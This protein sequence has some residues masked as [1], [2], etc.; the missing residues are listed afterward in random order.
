M[1][2]LDRIILK[3][4]VVVCFVFC[5]G[6]ITASAMT[7]KELIEKAQNEGSLLW[8]TS[9]PTASAEKL[10]KAFNE[11]YKV[12]VELVRSGGLG[13]IQ[14]VYAE[15]EKNISKC[16]VVG[17]TGATD[18]FPQMKR[19]GWL[20]KISDLPEWNHILDAMKD[21]DGLYV[22]INSDTVGMIYNKA[23]MEG[24][25]LPKSLKELADP[26]Y[27]GMLVVGDPSISGTALTWGRWV[28]H[29]KELGLDFLTKLR[30]ND[31]FVVGQTGQINDTVARG[32][33]AIGV[34]QQE[35]EYVRVMAKG[36][37]WITPQD[38]YV[39]TPRP[40]AILANAPH[41]VAARL[42][43]NYLL[44]PEVQD[45]MIQEGNS[46]SR[47][48]MNNNKYMSWKPPLEKGWQPNWEAIDEK[49]TKEM[50]TKISKALKGQ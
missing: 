3:L 38:G 24:K 18:A 1:D 8:Y 9:S 35:Y 15:Q 50:I 7:E 48:E 6:V 11:K 29:S 33:R 46:S 19:R 17:P 34:M 28:M 32:A 31:V 44:S 22:V 47:K 4:M 42:F 30:L 39:I 37:G 26:K 27:R 23:G 21:K 10:A 12:K 20:A 16:D 25:T 2:K 49:D 40:G 43:L 36:V 14:K 41:P 45:Q 13:T 5:L